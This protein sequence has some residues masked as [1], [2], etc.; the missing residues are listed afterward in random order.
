MSCARRQQRGVSLVEVMI[1]LALGLFI[2]GAAATLMVARLHEHRALLVESRLMQDLRVS[3]EIVMRDLRR[4]GYWGE[5]TAAMPEPGTSPVANP[6]TLVAVGATTADSV[7]FRFSRDAIENHTADSNEQ[8]GFRLRNGVIEMLLGGG[9]WQAMTDGTT[10]VVTAF[11]VTPA[12]Q[13]IALDGICEIPCPSGAGACGPKQ[14]VRSFAVAITGRSAA[15]SRVTRSVRST[16][17]LRNDAVA[18]A[19][20]V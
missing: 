20:P 17:R 19:C 9:S 3:S 4:A 15:D 18:G 14:Q 6:Y 1:G 16:V 10:M 8:F 11:S 5:P 7:S 13:E 2:V 12:V